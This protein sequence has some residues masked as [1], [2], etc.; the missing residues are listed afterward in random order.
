MIVN[1]TLTQ[2]ETTKYVN[3]IRKELETNFSKIKTEEVFIDNNIVR[4]NFSPK[5]ISETT[6]KIFIMNISM[7][8]KKVKIANIN[9]LKLVFTLALENNKYLTVKTETDNRYLIEVFAK[10]YS[11]VA[12]KDIIKMLDITRLGDLN[13]KSKRYFYIE[14][15]RRKPKDKLYNRMYR[16]YYQSRFAKENSVEYSIVE[17]D[18]KYQITDVSGKTPRFIGVAVAQA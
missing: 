12:I 15:G 14:A 13:T 3:I 8:V 4:L 11:E 5:D 18:N 17:I 9:T 7:E 6:K 2:E 16:V 10:Y 1:N